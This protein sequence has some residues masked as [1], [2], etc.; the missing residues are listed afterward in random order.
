MN[1]APN[2]NRPMR[3]MRPMPPNPKLRPGPKPNIKI[4]ANVTIPR[5]RK[6]HISIFHTSP[7]YSIITI[8]SIL[9]FLS[10]IIF[11]IVHF[12]AKKNNNNE[13]EYNDVEQDSVPDVPN[14]RYRR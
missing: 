11:T 8:L 3:P 4:N 12:T 5:P 7:F 14:K 9:L 1:N 6:H 13:N 10:I 2:L